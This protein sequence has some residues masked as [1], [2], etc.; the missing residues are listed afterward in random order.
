MAVCRAEPW[1]TWVF[2]MRLGRKVQKAFRDHGFRQEFEE[3][4]EKKYG[5]KYRW[6]TLEE[7]VEERM[8]ELENQNLSD[9]P[10]A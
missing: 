9:Q 3:W 4:Y 8:K 7:S 1:R 6:I 10:E 2:A 5:E